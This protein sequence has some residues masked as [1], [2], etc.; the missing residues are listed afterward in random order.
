MITYRQIITHDQEYTMEKE[1]RNQVLRVP[2][3]L[4]LSED[5][6]RGE[7]RQIHLVA[8]DDKGQVIGCVLVAFSENMAKIRQLAVDAGYRGRGIGTKLINGAEQAIRDRRI[9]MATIHARVTSQGFFEKLG[10]TA[11]SGVFTEVAIP[12][13]AMEKRFG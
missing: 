13:I 11:V 12:H 5:D 9:G 1:L 8:M 4:A 6:L 7:D 2:L 10:Y 3:G